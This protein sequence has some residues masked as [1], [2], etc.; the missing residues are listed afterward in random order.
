MNTPT[1]PR[2]PDDAADGHVRALLWRLRAKLVNPPDAD[3][4]Q[5]DLE[6]IFAA[7]SDLRRS[8]LRRSEVAR[9]ESEEAAGTNGPISDAPEV[10]SIAPSLDTPSGGAGDIDSPGDIDTTTDNSGEVVP[11]PS[12]LPQVASLEQRSSGLTQKIGRV[13]AVAVLIVGVGGGLAAAVD[14]EAVMI[15]LLGSETGNQAPD[16]D[17]SAGDHIAIEANTDQGPSGTTDEDGDTDAPDADDARDGGA[18]DTTSPSPSTGSDDDTADAPSDPATTPSQGDARDHGSE[19]N[20]A[21]GS[22]SSG[23][24]DRS[25]GSEEGSSGREQ[26]R[27]EEPVD[28]NTTIVAQPD[29]PVD[30]GDLDGFGGAAP[31]ETDDLADCVNGRSPADDDAADDDAA[32]DEDEDEEDDGDTEEDEEED[33]DR[34]RELADRRFQG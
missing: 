17:S 11:I 5:A 22:G 23:S 18:A 4:A 10:A 29:G 21:T 19:D 20:S 16:P 6:R 1:P 15:A 28:D 12:Q 26:P 33:E 13:A 2:I 30:Q 7:A 9:R 3:R 14:R 31:C 27:Q 32:D 25:K 24:S 8:D 34:L